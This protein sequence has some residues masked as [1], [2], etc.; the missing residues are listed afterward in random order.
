MIFIYIPATLLILSAAAGYYL[1]RKSLNPR[2][3]DYE[4]SYRTEVEN[5]KFDDQWFR[6]LDKEEVYTTSREG[7]RLHGLWHPAKDSSK[8]VIF[9]HGYSYSL[10]GSVKYMK[11][12]SDRGFNILLVDHRYHGLSEGKICTMGH[13]EKM[14]VVKWVNWVEDRVGRDT[15]I[16]THGESM[17]AATALLHGEVDDRVNFIISDCAYQSLSDQFRYRLKKEFKMPAFPLLY[18]GN[19]FSK[20]RAGLSY[21]KV[22]P[23]ESVKKVKIPIL[24]IHG[25]DDN[26]TTPSNSINLHKAKN[27][28]GFIYLV[29]GAG[30]GKSYETNPDNYKKVVYRFLDNCG[31]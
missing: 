17:G 6:N 16:G 7:Y 19:L 21:G 3:F 13:K 25:Q 15:I 2:T 22:S 29:P 31:V 20:M 14:D 11:M 30:H 8:T 23:V 27:G 5:N 9:I 26:Y 28:P 18:L 10:Y 4:E 1:S 24:F 12:F